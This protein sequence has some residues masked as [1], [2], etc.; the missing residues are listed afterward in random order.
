VRQYSV[1]ESLMPETAD[2]GRE[3]FLSLVYRSGLA[4]KAVVNS[5]R[6]AII[7]EGNAPARTGIVA[8]WFGRYTMPATIRSANKPAQQATCSY[9]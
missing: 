1:V 9:L 8:R 4:T 6:A 5:V 2:A 7:Q 3:S